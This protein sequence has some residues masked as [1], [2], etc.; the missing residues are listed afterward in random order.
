MTLQRQYC[1]VTTVLEGNECFCAAIATLHFTQLAG[2]VRALLCCTPQLLDRKCTVPR[3]LE[4]S[5]TGLIVDCV[6]LGIALTV[7]YSI[8]ITAYSRHVDC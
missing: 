5:S 4:L 8:S 6:P 2:A 1:A 7:F 3:E